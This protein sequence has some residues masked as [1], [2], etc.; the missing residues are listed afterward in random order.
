MV[1]NMQPMNVSSGEVVMPYSGPDPA[2]GT[3]QHNIAFIALRQQGIVQVAGTFFNMMG[4]ESLEAAQE[5]EPASEATGQQ[6]AAALEEA[7]LEA[8]VHGLLV[9]SKTEL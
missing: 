5:A 7:T 4:P 2:A 6:G 1:V 8:A 3:D 9:D